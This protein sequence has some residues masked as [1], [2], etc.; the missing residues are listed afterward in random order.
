MSKRLRKIA[1]VVGLAF[2][3]FI[4]LKSCEYDRQLSFAPKGLGVSKVLYATEGAWGF[5]PGGNETGIIVYEL[6]ESAV[7]GIEQDG[8]TY[9]EKLPQ[10]HNI[11]GSRDWHG[12]YA[13]WMPTPMRLEGSDNNANRTL[14]YD[15]DEYLNRYG[16]GINL[17][18]QVRQEINDAISQVGS[19]AAYG[20]IGL[21]VVM[22]KTRKVIYAHNG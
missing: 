8:L 13:H 7:G 15:I 12:I 4:F 17:G 14:S 10:S 22:P 11:S 5:G 9:L 19:F 16:F 18:P 6:S 21:V 3:A 2:G 1:T 20:R